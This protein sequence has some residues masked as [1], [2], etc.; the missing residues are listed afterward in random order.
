[1]EMAGAADRPDRAD[2]LVVRRHARASSGP[3][4]AEPPIR[5]NLPRRRRRHRRDRRVAGGP[6]HAHCGRFRVPGVAWLANVTHPTPRRRR[7]RLPAARRCQRRRSALRHRALPPVNPL[8][9][10]RRTGVRSGG[11]PG[12]HRVSLG[13]GGPTAPASSRPRHAH[14]A[15]VLPERPRRVP[16][17]TRVST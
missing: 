16:R 17:P 2:A 3:P 4:G 7:R 5:R 9:D 6:R 13:T 10:R 15:P 8:A 1:M 11:A 12:R 14:R